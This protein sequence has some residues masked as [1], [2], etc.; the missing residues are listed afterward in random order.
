MFQSCT[1]LWTS[2]HV[3]S[4]IA[5]TFIGHNGLLPPLT[6]TIL[7]VCQST[8]L[9]QKSISFLCSYYF[10]F[11]VFQRFLPPTAQ[12][13][14]P[15]SCN[16]AYLPSFLTAFSTQ[17]DR[18]FLPN[19]T[20]PHGILSFETHLYCTANYFSTHPA[21]LLAV[22]PLLATACPLW[23][24]TYQWCY[25]FMA[26]RL[27]SLIME[28]KNIW[29]IHHGWIWYFVPFDLMRTFSEQRLGIWLLQGRI[30]ISTCEDLRVGS[31][32]WLIF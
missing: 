9:I 26:F 7:S 11:H 29:F 6:P 5:I 25:E 28:S 1:H 16:P 27:L 13:N 14:I 23:F 15:H 32:A 17:L 22:N 4:S 10:L 30:V 20:Q 8:P 3:T 18:C 31:I 21:C 19:S 2:T 12:L 24:V